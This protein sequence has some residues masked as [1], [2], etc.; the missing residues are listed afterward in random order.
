M[1]HFRATIRESWDRYVATLCTAAAG[2]LAALNPSAGIDRLMGG[3]PATFALGLLL[4]F[5]SLL[6]V[7]GLAK[8]SFLLQRVGLVIQI[9]MLALFV[10][11]LGLVT[12]GSAIAYALLLVA[13]AFRLVS[14][15]RL[16]G[17][18]RQLVAAVKA[19]DTT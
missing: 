4:A 18:T 15:F 12:G 9:T 5:G 14:Q 6:N 8:P 13:L 17:K 3:F 19:S 1:W 10:V 16:L 2:V 7:A 11:A